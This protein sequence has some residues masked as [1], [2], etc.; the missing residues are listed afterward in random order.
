MRTL[1]QRTRGFT[2]IELLVVIAIIAILIAILLP[3]VQKAREAAFRTKCENNIKQLVLALHNYHDSHN[4]FPP[5][6]ISTRPPATIDLS[7]GGFRTVDPFEPID[8][9][10]STNVNGVPVGLHGMSW[11][12]HVLPYIEKDNLYQLWRTDLNVF[13]NAERT[14][15]VQWTRLGYAPATFDIPEFYCPSRRSKMGRTG[16]EFSQNFYLDSFSPSK[17]T[18]GA[19]ISGGNDYAGCAG[20][21]LVFTH[22]NNNTTIRAAFDLTPQQVAFQSATPSANYNQIGQNVGVF[23]TNSSVR[24]GDIKDGTSQTIMIGEAER[25]SPFPRTIPVRT[26]IQYAYDGWAWGGPATLF[27]TQFGPNQMVDFESAGASHGD[28]CIVGLADG[29]AHKIGK[30]IGLPVWQALG[31][32]SGGITATNF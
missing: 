28:I 13:Y 23:T 26:A 2:L 10:F 27:S 12:F 4:A 1:R 31:N 20:S 25:F 11:M 15:D 17:L 21:G 19:V 7:P 32:M 14:R 6:M 29:S 5:G 16:G 24:M 9:Q 22:P 3:A 30:S 18:T 8:N